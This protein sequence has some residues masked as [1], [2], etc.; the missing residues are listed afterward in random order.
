MLQNTWFGIHSPH[1]GPKQNEFYQAFWLIVKTLIIPSLPKST[2][3]SHFQSETGV[4]LPMNSAGHPRVDV[5][6]V[7]YERIMAS[8]R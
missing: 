5:M 1:D 7:I 2:S 4:G 3:F 8:R 6:F